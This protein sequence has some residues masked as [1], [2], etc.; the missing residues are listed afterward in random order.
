MA[1]LFFA[2]I[3]TVALQGIAS[4]Q[5]GRP[6]PSSDLPPGAK[7]LPPPV[8][9]DALYKQLRTARDPNEARPIAKQIEQ[10]WMR[11]GSDTTNLLMDRV[12]E[13]MSAKAY[14]T[15]LELLDHILQLQPNWAEAYAKRATLLFLM[16]DYD[17]AMRDL[18]AVLAREPRHFSAL[19]GLGMIWQRLGKP[20]AAYAAYQKVLEV[21]PHLVEVREIVDRMRPEVE[22]REL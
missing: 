1:R 15:G 18:R 14:D 17:G 2:I 11:S 9:L 7:V 12:L 16:D 6:A 10:R 19:A 4:A 8:T 20:K 22:G 5:Q 3:L 13:V 21:Y